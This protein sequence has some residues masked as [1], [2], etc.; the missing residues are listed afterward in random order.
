MLPEERRNAAYQALGEGLWGVAMGFVAP[1]TVLPLLLKTLGAGPLQ[2]GVLY[3]IFTAGFLITQPLGMVLFQHGAGKKRFLLL[4]H[5]FTIVPVTLAMAAAIYFQASENPRLTRFL[6]LSLLAFRTLVI[7]MVV[8]I[9]MDW[10]AGLFRT[11]SRG[12]AIGLAWAAWSFGVTVSAIV[13]AKIHHGLAFPGNY[14][15]LFLISTVVFCV[16][17]GTF[18][19]M[20]SGAVPG[21]V[22]QRLS[23]RSLLGRFSHSLREVNFRDY[24][25][26][27]VL[28][29]M[30]TGAT[31]FFAVYFKS[32]RGGDLSAATII[33]FGACMTLTSALMSYL[34]GSLGDKTGH[35]IG[36]VLGSAAQ[37]ASLTVA[38]L[39]RG[40]IA[41]VVTFILVGAARAA[42]LVSH[43]NMIYETC[44]HDSRVAH[45]TLSNLVLGPFML[46]VPLLTGWLIKHVGMESGIA[47]CLIPTVLGA[48]WLLL[49][50]RNPREIELPISRY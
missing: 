43:Q 36:V 50:M 35:K 13:A 28:L 49:K 5:L 38:W 44:P 11:R 47:L 7:G 40:E 12:R 39:A 21:E 17:M 23:L 27:R 29:T 9:W 19:F 4:Y 41:C 33:A 16:S 2:L 1:L 42:A 22:R 18:G 34:L 24:L 37:I 30:G 6:L 46:A 8:P 45:I 20:S 32:A 25:V 26:G 48:L 15:L 3:S 31:A 10:I 14:T